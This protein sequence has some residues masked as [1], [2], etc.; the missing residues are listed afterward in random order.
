MCVCVCVTYI[1]IHTFPPK[2]HTFYVSEIESKIRRH[3]AHTF[4]PKKHTFYVSEI[5]SKILR[6][7]ALIIEDQR[8][9]S[10]LL[11]L[12]QACQGPIISL[13]KT[14]NKCL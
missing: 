8:A 7:K 5:E 1:H 14:K 3:K 12:L 9:T 11:I 2:K 4:P 10:S 6:H 13:L